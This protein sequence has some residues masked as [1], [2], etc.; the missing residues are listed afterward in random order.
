MHPM[1]HSKGKRVSKI[2]DVLIAAG[3]VFVALILVTGGLH[4]KVAGV[5]L[6]KADRIIKPL[7]VVLALF[8]LRLFLSL[9]K[10]DFVLLVGTVLICL[11]GAELFFRIWDPPLASGLVQ[12]HRPSDVYGWELVPGAVGVGALGET[13]RINEAG[14]R[15]EKHDLVKKPGACR[16]AAIGDSF[17]YGMGVLLENTYIKQL[18][19]RLRREGVSCETFNFGVIGHNMWQH[20]RK[21]AREALRYSP[22][23]VVLGLYQD[24]LAQSRPPAN[25]EGRVPGQQIDRSPTL[26]DRVY[27]FNYLKNVNRILEYKYRYRQGHGYLRG[28]E[29]RKAQF[30]ARNQDDANYRIMSGNGVESLYRSFSR[31]LKKFKQT[32]TTGAARGCWWH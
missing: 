20:Y 32:A 19:D 14:W 4:L 3:G 30:G 8:F 7:L 27:L 23:L 28:I 15:D 9:K 22:D 24:D 21:L 10:K 6:L 1:K 29:E 26:L 5:S 16:I 2:L 25:R 18:E 13:I 11:A 31:V 17:T 12:I